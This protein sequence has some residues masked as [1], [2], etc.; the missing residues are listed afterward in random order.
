MEGK[1]MFIDASRSFYKPG[2][3]KDERSSMLDVVYKKLYIKMY[4]KNSTFIG[5]KRRLTLY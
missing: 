5:V 2:Q 3:G 1:K 4:I